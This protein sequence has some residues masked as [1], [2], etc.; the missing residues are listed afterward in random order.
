MVSP[1]SKPEWLGFGFPR[2]WDSDVL[3]IL[4]I[5]TE[6]GYR[7]ERM[8]EAVGLLRDKGDRTYRQVS[9]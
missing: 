5:L 4:K 9:P 1:H 7:D 8:R 2:M 6:L 3:E